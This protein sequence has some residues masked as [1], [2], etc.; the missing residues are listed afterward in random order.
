MVSSKQLFDY[1]PG[2][3]KLS[4]KTFTPLKNWQNSGAECII[5]NGYAAFIASKTEP[6][7]LIY[8]EKVYVRNLND[9]N[10]D[11]TTPATV[12]KQKYH[13]RYEETTRNIVKYFSDGRLFY[14]LNINSAPKP[15]GSEKHAEETL[16]GQ[17]VIQACGEHLCIQDNYVA[18]YVFNNLDSTN[19]KFTLSYSVS[20][21]KKCYEITT[22]FERI[23]SVDL[24][25]L[26]IQI[27][28]DAIV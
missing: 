9:S 27:K 21:P 5:A 4:R 11:A 24:I 10:L 20:G 8:S 12:A 13:Y 14:E 19:S 2:I 15:E 23:N 16:S 25:E 3:W 22:E 18:N 26:D 1:L 7:L 17:S 28:S 6:N